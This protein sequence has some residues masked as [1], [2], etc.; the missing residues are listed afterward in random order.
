MIVLE[1][2]GNERLPGAQM[3]CNYVPRPEVEYCK[4]QHCPR[5]RRFLRDEKFEFEGSKAGNK[6]ISVIRFDAPSLLFSPA[7]ICIGVSS[8]G[9]LCRGFPL[10]SIFISIFLLRFHKRW[11]PRIISQDQVCMSCAAY[12]CRSSFMGVGVLGLYVQ[13]LQ[14]LI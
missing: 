11:Y 12:P 1:N 3:G 9:F 7:S 5:Q 2:P 4:T 8:C 13:G 6:D 10:L 14:M